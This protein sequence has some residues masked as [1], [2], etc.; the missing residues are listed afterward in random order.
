MKIL[1]TGGTG[2]IGSHTVVELLNAGYEV[3]IAD[4]L[5]DANRSCG[6]FLRGIDY[7]QLTGNRFINHSKTSVDA[8]GDMALSLW[9][10]NELDLPMLAEEAS[11]FTVP[12]E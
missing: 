10:A 5:F 6:L 12:A 11:V 1:V 4:N 7:S 3:V 2:F 9:Y 8:R